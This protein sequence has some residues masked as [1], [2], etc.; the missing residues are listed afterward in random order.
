MP[1]LGEYQM[2]KPVGKRIHRSD[3]FIPVRYCEC[4]AG[5]EVVLQI[6]N[7]KKI[8]VEQI[9]RALVH[10]MPIL[11]LAIDLGQTSRQMLDTGSLDSTPHGP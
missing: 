5:S 6:N 7:D 3:Y 4:T 1:I 10:G 2:R 9:R 8:V 11:L